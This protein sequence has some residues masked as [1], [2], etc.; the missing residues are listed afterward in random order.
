ME[1]PPPHVREDRLARFIFKLIPLLNAKEG[2]KKRAKK[3]ANRAAG[4]RKMEPNSSH[5]TVHRGNENKWKRR[6]R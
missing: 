1:P 5:V 6:G 4:E 3:K 2:K